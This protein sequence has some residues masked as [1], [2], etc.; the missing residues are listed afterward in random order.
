MTQFKE[1]YTKLYENLSDDDRIAFDSLNQNS[2][3]SRCTRSKI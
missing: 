3:K 1:K 2:I